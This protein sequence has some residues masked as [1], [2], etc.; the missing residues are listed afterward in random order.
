VFVYDVYV[1]VCVCVCVCMYTIHQLPHQQQVD[2]FYEIQMK[3]T[4][5]ISG[6]TRTKEGKRDDTLTNHTDDTKSVQPLL[7]LQLR[8][9]VSKVILST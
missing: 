1:C 3:E 2:Q 6:D 8:Y 7:H 5:L 9:S 4:D